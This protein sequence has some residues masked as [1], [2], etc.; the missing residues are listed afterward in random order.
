M[1][2]A[3]KPFALLT[4]PPQGELIILDHTGDTKIIWDRHNRDEVS[5]AKKTYDDL[6]KKGFMA[7]SVKDNGEKKELIDEFDAEAERIIMSPRQVGG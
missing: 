6:K 5:A 1:D 4:P 3:F 2:T 7:Y